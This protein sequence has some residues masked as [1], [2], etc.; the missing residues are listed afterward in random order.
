MQ[1]NLAGGSSYFLAEWIY[2]P[3]AAVPLENGHNLLEQFN[4]VAADVYSTALYPLFYR[5]ICS[6]LSA[7]LDNNEATIWTGKIL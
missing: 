1:V 7:H 3:P 6:H 4:N 5:F 2:R